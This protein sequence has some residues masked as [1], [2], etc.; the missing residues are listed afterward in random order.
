MITTKLSNGGELLEDSDGNKFYLL[1]GDLHRINGPAVEWMTGGKAW[2]V[3]G[4]RHRIDGPATEWSSGHKQWCLD[5]KDIPCTTQKEFEQL[6]RL[7]A[8]W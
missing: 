6:M 7:K 2:W 4:K 5:G 1:N 8:F 3:N